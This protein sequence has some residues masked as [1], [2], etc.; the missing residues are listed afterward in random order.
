MWPWPRDPPRMHRVLSSHEAPLVTGT[1]VDRPN[2]F[3]LRVDINGSTE[4]VYLAD[5]GELSFL[6]RGVTVLCSPAEGA[7][8][9][10][11]WDAVAARIADTYIGL[12]PALANQLFLEA[13][14]AGFL[15]MFDGYQYA[16]SE[17]AYP[18]RGR[19][20][21]R[22]TPPSGDHDVYVEI[23]SCT[24]EE[25]G[26]GKFP[27]RPTK[28]GRRHLRCL[29]SIVR[30]GNEAHVVFVAQHPDITSVTP[31]REVDPEFADLLSEIKTTGVHVHAIGTAF[32]PPTYTLQSPD[33][34]VETA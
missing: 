9:T 23:K 3:V 26:V 14:R 1:V 20:D 17:P 4:R 16:E 7:D 21:F 28:R 25:S 6:E 15:P 12:K 30:G 2:R 34:P 29:Q 19:G 5:P 8:R 22:L 32:E 13:F 27:D 24:H 18:V 33:M 11:S 10:T 31:F